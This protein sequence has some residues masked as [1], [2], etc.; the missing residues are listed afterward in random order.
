MNAIPSAAVIRFFLNIMYIVTISWTNY[1]YYP[2]IIISY[3]SIEL[4]TL[5]KDIQEIVCMWCAQLFFSNRSAVEVKYVLLI[6]TLKYA[7]NLRFLTLNV[8]CVE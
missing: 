7:T 5:K 4:L 2:I 6:S 3:N 8:L 1:Y